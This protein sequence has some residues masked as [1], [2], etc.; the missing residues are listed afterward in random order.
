MGYHE[1]AAKGTI[2][3]TLGRH[4][5]VADVDWAAMV[6]V[7]QRLMPQLVVS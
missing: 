5:T 3:L 4:T 1:S 2:R 7:L 6:Q